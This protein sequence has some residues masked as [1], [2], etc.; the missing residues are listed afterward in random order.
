VVDGM[1]VTLTECSKIKANSNM[2]FLLPNK[3]LINKSF[4][5]IFRGYTKKEEAL[6]FQAMLYFYTQSRKSRALYMSEMR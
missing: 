3:S 6:C 4:A 2:T 5:D 1:E